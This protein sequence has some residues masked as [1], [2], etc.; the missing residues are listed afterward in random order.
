MTCSG[1]SS[2]FCGGPNRLNVYKYTGT[3]LPA[4]GTTGNA[5]NGVV[6]ATSGGSSVL[7]VLSGLQTGWAYNA[8]WV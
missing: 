4:T 2:E 3:N 1:N 8:C 5:G 6:A 7:P